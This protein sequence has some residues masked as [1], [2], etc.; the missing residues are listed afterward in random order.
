[1]IGVIV[2]GHGHFATGITSSLEL[3]MGKQENYIPVDFPEGD[4]KTE[5]EN[6]IKEAINH[7]K[8]MDNI[9]VFTDLL[10]GSPFNVMILEALKDERIRVVYGT[11]L[12]MLIESIMKRNIGIAFEELVSEAVE[13]G[14]AQVGVFEVKEEEDDDSF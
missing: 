11:N 5:L 13:T 1:M 10:S 6:N 9:L 14:K 7:M 2:C 4:T 3:I 12:G 8:D